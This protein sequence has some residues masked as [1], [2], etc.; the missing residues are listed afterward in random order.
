MNVMHKRERLRLLRPCPEVA[1]Q[2]WCAL[3]RPQLFLFCESETSTTTL[4]LSFSSSITFFSL[5]RES[6]CVCVCEDLLQPLQSGL[7]GLKS[8]YKKTRRV[9][10]HKTSGRLQEWEREIAVNLKH[11]EKILQPKIENCL[12]KVAQDL[13]HNKIQL[14]KHNLEFKLGILK[15][16]KI[17]CCRNFKIIAIKIKNIFTGDFF[18]NELLP[19]GSKKKPKN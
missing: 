1:I 18:C 9:T 14:N 13:K 3:L 10:S 16:F 5:T 4:S 19:N 6:Q 17:N 11:C 7:N 8:E 12:K 2:Q 15:Q